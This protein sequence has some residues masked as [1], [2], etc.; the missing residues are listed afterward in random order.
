LERKKK[1]SLLQHDCLVCVLRTNGTQRASGTLN[2]FCE[3]AQ[4]DIS[5]NWCLWSRI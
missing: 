5:S 2:T 4:D 3:S 1:S